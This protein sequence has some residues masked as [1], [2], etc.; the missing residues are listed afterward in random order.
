MEDLQEKNE[1]LLASVFSLDHPQW[2]LSPVW[3]TWPLDVQP[4]LCGLHNDHKEVLQ[5]CAPPARDSLHWNPHN[6]PLPFQDTQAGL[7]ARQTQDEVKKL[8]VQLQETMSRLE[9]L[10]SECQEQPKQEECVSWATAGT[11]D[12]TQRLV[13]SDFYQLI[14]AFLQVCEHE[15]AECYPHPRPQLHPSGPIIQTIDQI[16]TS[17]S[18]LLKVVVE[19]T[20]ALG[21]AME[22]VQ[23]QPCEQ[24]CW[25]SS[26][27][28][29]SLAS[30]I[31]ELLE[32]YKV[33]GDKLPNGDQASLSQ[34]H[35]QEEP[36]GSLRPS[37]APQSTEEAGAEWDR[38]VSK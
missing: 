18:Q 23:W 19:V 1:L 14:L 26:S 25:A 24:L 13:T 34:S 16:L 6:Q 21:Q 9:T 11:L 2:L 37:V 33:S 3:D 20:A 38:A 10:R 36:S 35:L 7:S 12:Q 28:V 4:L 8:V 29:E 30:D 31:E 17:Y 15:L 32:K 5:S 27:S 22:M